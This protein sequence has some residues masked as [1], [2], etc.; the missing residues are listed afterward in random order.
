MKLV[1]VFVAVLAGVGGVLASGSEG[2]PAQLEVA[3]AEHMNGGRDGVVTRAVDC[4]ATGAGKADGF[5]CVL[6]ST[7]GTKLVARVRVDG[8]RWS[9]DWEP[10]RG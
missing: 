9:A 4:F 8:D 3:I 5:R 6:T 2:R 7:R 10:L 1:A